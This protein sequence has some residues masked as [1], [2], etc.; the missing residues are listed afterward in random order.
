MGNT[1][2]IILHIISAACPC[3]AETLTLIPFNTVSEQ[4]LKFP[5]L[6]LF[7]EDRSTNWRFPVVHNLENIISDYA[8]AHCL[9]ILDNFRQVNFKV[10]RNSQSPVII[11]TNT[12]Y[13]IHPSS[14]HLWGIFGPP[15]LAHRNITRSWNGIFNCP[16]SKFL[17][18]MDG[19]KYHSDI[20]HKLVMANVWKYIKPWN[21]IVQMAI[22]PTLHYYN[23]YGLLKIDLNRFTIRPYLFPSFPSLELQFFLHEWPPATPKNSCDYNNKD[24]VQLLAHAGLQDSVIEE[25]FRMVFLKFTVSVGTR[26][27]PIDAKLSDPVGLIVT[28]EL[29]RVWPKLQHKNEIILIPMSRLLN[30]SFLRESVLPPNL[31]LVWFIVDSELGEN[32]FGYMVQS[33]WNDRHDSSFLNQCKRHDF[34]MN[35]VKQVGRAYADIWLDIM[36]NVSVRSADWGMHCRIEDNCA[37]I[38]TS[39]TPYVKG[40]LYFPYFIQDEMSTLGFVSCGESKLSSLPFREL[41]SVFDGWIWLMLILTMIAVI[42]PLRS[43]SEVQVGSSSSWLSPLKLFLEQGDPYLA[44]VTNDRRMRWFI[45]TFLLAGI[46]LSN[47][48]KNENIYNMITPRNPILYETLE[49]LIRNNFTIYSRIIDLDASV[50]YYKIHATIRSLEVVHQKYV[51]LNKG[52]FHGIAVPEISVVER[53]L[54]NALHSLYLYKVG[55]A[56]AYIHLWLDH[57]QFINLLRVSKITLTTH[58]TEIMKVAIENVIF[59][60]EGRKKEGNPFYRLLLERQKELVSRSESIIFHNLLKDCK[61]VAVIQ[62]KYLCRDLALKVKSDGKRTNVVVGRESYSDLLWLFYLR[63]ALPHQLPTRIKTT[64]EAGIWWRWLALFKKTDNNGNPPDVAPARMDGNIM[65]VFLIW[66]FGQIAATCCYAYEACVTIFWY[67]VLAHLKVFV[68]P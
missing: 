55:L 8:S 22:Y 43:L 6:D 3:T 66:M 38:T 4:N 42:I 23:I 20:C 40:S 63:G 5:L 27:F 58:V 62:S 24:F 26:A 45:G 28:V 54:V 10:H 51:Y 67:E 11:R 15:N 13:S 59:S 31:K 1:F 61:N 18:G 21:C 30:F 44:S 14:A 64:Y 35:P 9:I 65:V 39:F 46:V 12:L 49:E 25:Y 36:T 16:L 56:S 34:V 52:G 50:S 68:K 37:G 29:M 48:Y 32:I 41:T 2:H 7:P 33:L 47:A 57:A 17:G 19:W 60:E 53:T